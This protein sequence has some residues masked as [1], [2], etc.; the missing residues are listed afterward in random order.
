[1]PVALRLITRLAVSFA[2]TDPSQSLI[3]A[4][5]GFLIWAKT[6]G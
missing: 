4:V 3:F 5:V 1:M 2:R 6:Q